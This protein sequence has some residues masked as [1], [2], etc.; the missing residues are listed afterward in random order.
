MMS[1]GHK[2]TSSGFLCSGKKS[3]FQHLKPLSVYSHIV[4]REQYGATSPLCNIQIQI[5]NKTAGKRRLDDSC[6]DD[7]CETPLKKRRLYESCSPDQGCV[8]DSLDFQTG[9]YGSTPTQTKDVTPPCPPLAPFM[10]TPVSHCTGNRFVHVRESLPSP[11]PVLNWDRDMQF[12]P[13]RASQNVDS[14]NSFNVSLTGRQAD[15]KG[16]RGRPLNL[17]VEVREE[18]VSEGQ[19]TEPKLDIS[20]QNEESFESSLP[21]QVQVKSK[22]VVP[23]TTKTVCQSA[24]TQSERKP[25]CDIY[26]RDRYPVQRSVPCCGE[27][28]KSAKKAYVESVIRHMETNGARDGVMTELHHLMNTVAGQRHGQRSGHDGGHWQHP[29]DLTRRNYRVR[30]PLLSLSEWQ[31]RNHL[32]LRRFAKVPDIFHRSPVL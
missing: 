6:L 21:L 23:E 9:V 17:H 10:S 30:G 13:L 3:S 15:G 4:C 11:I 8:V 1:E 2:Y 28:W 16:E 26:R 25:E 29:S 20:Y 14:C 19:L 12:I 31:K 18:G 32:G 5:T 27:D 24:A 22:V 7:T